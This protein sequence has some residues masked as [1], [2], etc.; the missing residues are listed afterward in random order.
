MNAAK[1]Q[2]ILYAGLRRFQLK[3]RLVGKPLVLKGDEG[4][5]IRDLLEEIESQLELRIP[6]KDWMRPVING[7]PVICEHELSTQYN[8]YHGYVS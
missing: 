3:N 6:D 2:R 8:T 7:S 4:I 5:I 1:L